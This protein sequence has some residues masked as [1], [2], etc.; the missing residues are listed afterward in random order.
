MVKLLI[1]IGISIGL[2]Y[3]IGFIIPSLLKSV[4]KYQDRPEV[5]IWKILIAGIQATA[6]IYLVLKG[7]QKSA[8]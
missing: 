8:R 2:L 3:L 1:V 7:V 5:E 4:S 6:V